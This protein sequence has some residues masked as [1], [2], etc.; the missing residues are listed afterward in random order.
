MPPGCPVQRVPEMEARDRGGLA[1]RVMRNRIV[2]AFLF[3]LGG[4]GI[5]AIFFFGTLFVLNWMEIRS[6]DAI[7]IGHAK[8]LKDALNRYHAARGTFPVTFPDNP[9]ED[10]KPALVDGGYLSAI[11]NDPLPTRTY[12]YTTGSVTNGQHYALKIPLEGP[13]SCVTG[14]D[15]EGSGWWS[16]APVCPF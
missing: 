8:L 11:P 2:R 4:V 9:I 7:R 12:R 15:F 3:C 5:V 10:L 14:V 13:G 6:R 16:P 1:L